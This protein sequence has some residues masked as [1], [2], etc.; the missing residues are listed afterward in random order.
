[1]DKNYNSEEL[2]KIAKELKVEFI[3]LQLSDMYGVIKNISITIEQLEKTLDNE[4]R[5]DESVIDIFRKID[6]SN[7][8]L[9]Y[10]L[11]TF[12]VLPMI[13]GDVVVMKVKVNESKS[14]ENI[15]S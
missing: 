3:H 2:L 15:V 7:I 8:F 10:D 11:C 9:G 14:N 4:S 13:I 1:M 5:L 12:E 6:E